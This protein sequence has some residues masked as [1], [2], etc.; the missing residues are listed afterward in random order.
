MASS[1]PFPWPE[2]ALVVRE[3]TIERPA[4]PVVDAHNH[5]SDEFGAGWFRRDPNELAEAMDTAGVETF[6]DLDGAWGEDVLLHRLDTFKAALGDRYQVATGVDWSRWDDKGAAFG[7]W[8]AGRLAEDVNRGAVGIK[9]W[10]PFGLE[11]TDHAGALV[12]VDTEQMDP[13]WEAAGQL[14]VPV[15][16][17]TADPVAFF[18]PIDEHNER[19][20]EL[21]EFPEWGFS[22]ERFPSFDELMG[23]L[24]RLVAGHPATTFVGAHVGCYA[25]NLG[26]VG[27][28]LD[29]YPNFNVDIA[30]RLG[31]LGR[32][33]HTARRFFIEYADRILFGLD[34]PGFPDLYRVYYRF[35]ETD[36]ENFDYGVGPRPGQGRWRIHGIHLPD[37]VL[38][39][40]YRT[41]AQRIFHL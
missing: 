17:H 4:F 7:V 34:Y 11:I 35:L 33:P 37:D 39:Q 30:A 25:E 13:L 8:A 1:P 24:E 36:D 15:V 32:Q 31:E 41:N 5:L 10:K 29:R 40:I 22:G 20:D 14:D 16:I 27:R 9:I 28:M 21:A 18:D 26:W 2:P 6:I 38:E 12:P 23:Q 19:T 3:T